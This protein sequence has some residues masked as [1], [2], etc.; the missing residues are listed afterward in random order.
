M[1]IFGMCR[2]LP[3][4]SLDRRRTTRERFKELIGEVLSQGISPHRLAL[5]V[6]LGIIIGILPAFWGATLICALIAFFLR[7]NQAV[8]QVANYLA[9]P[10]QI[11]LCLPFYRIGAKI[12][13]WG[14]SFS[15]KALFPWLPKNWPGNILLFIVASLKAI[16][17][18]LIIAPL[19]GILLYPLLL[20]IFNRIPH[21]VRNGNVPRDHCK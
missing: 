20:R 13:T 18:W 5:T 1:P 21:I 12:F 16:C 3:H 6:A 17:A 14:P 10:L 11:A 15:N 9:Y 19:A 2:R 4:F 7:L 8:I